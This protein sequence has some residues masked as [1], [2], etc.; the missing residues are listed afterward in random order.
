MS[1][2]RVPV[3][4]SALKVNQAAIIVLL[5]LAFILDIAALV[6]LTAAVMLFGTALNRPGFGFLYTRLFKPLGWVKPDVLRDHREPHR[7]AQ[8]FGGVVLAAS[9]ILLW[10][11]LH[12][13]GWALTWLVIALAA[14]NLFAGFCAGCAMYYWFNRLN[15]P[16]FEKSPPDGTTAGM[17]PK[18]R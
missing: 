2:Q 12:V 18:A 4:H 5:L 16:G 6:A 11:G 1:D 15:L 14:L 7:F 17:R 8:G 13:A 9:A 3:D 10:S